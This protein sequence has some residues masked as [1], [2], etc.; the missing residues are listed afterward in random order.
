MKS[1]TVPVIQDKATTS[2]FFLQFTQK[3]QN[4]TIL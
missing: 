4:L 3:V 1:E 2:L